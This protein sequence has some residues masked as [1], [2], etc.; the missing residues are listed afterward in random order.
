M[1]KRIHKCSATQPI[2]YE[3]QRR[4]EHWYVDNQVYFITARCTDRYAAFVTS[5]AQ[6]IF[7]DRWGHYAEEHQFTPWII[8]LVANHYHVLG[9]CKSGDGFGQMMRKTH[10]S[11][12]KLVNDTLP[13]RRVPFWSGP[14]HQDYFDGCIRSKKQCRL[15]FRYIQT[16]C[17][18]HGICS[19]WR[20]YRNTRVLVE[21]ERGVKRALE[22]DAFM[23]GVPY[24]R[25]MRKG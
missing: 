18:R 22:I 11:I 1:P 25:C 13:Q 20:E 6:E 3:G 23:E 9:Y 8:S 7:W 17:V 16:Q 12:A 10:G 21:L 24:K 15:A 5:A 2:A 4:F 14:G 19:D